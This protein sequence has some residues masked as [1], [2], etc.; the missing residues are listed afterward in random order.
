[1]TAWIK[2]GI[3]II[4]INLAQQHCAGQRRLGFRIAAKTVRRLSLG[5]LFIALGVQRRLSA[6]GRGQRDGRAGVDKHIIGCGEF[7]Q[8]KPCFLAGIAQLIVGCK[9]H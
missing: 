2:H 3:E 7:F 6:L 9:D 1:M 4:G 8:P 5:V